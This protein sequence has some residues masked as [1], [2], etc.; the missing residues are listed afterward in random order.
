MSKDLMHTKQH[1]RFN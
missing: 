1:T